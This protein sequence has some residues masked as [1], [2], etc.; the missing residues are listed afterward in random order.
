MLFLPVQVRCDFHAFEL[1]LFGGFNYALIFALDESD[2]RCK[3]FCPLCPSFLYD[4]PESP[5]VFQDGTKIRLVPLCF[6]FFVCFQLSVIMQWTNQSIFLKTFFKKHDIFNMTWL[7][8]TNICSNLS[9]FSECR[10]VSPLVQR[11]CVALWV[12]VMPVISC[13]LILKGN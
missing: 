8:C 7:I 4:P 2:I 6:C 9:S 3:S 5:P 13:V 10:G 12:K 1:C 11:I